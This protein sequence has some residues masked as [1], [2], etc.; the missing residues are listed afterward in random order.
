MQLE[1][2]GVEM[3]NMRNLL[4][5]PIHGTALPKLTKREAFWN[6]NATRHTCPRDRIRMSGRSD[7]A[8][9]IP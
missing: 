2:I 1:S 4:K 6:R 7:L 5:F 9:S 8:A 3:L